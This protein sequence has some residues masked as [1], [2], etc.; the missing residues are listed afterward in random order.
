MGCCVCVWG[1]RE[2]VS[3]FSNLTKAEESCR[4]WLEKVLAITKDLIGLDFAADPLTWEPGNEQC[5]PHLQ[6]CSSCNRVGGLGP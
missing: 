1:G 6:R 4:V 5:K 3:M 2:G